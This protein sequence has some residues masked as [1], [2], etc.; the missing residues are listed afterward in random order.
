MGRISAPFGVGGQ[1]RIQPF[2]ATTGGLIAY[3]S[4]W[5]G[6]DGNWREHK[7]EH[8][9]V[10]GRAVVAKLEHCDDRD[11]AMLLRGMQVAIPREVLPHTNAGE[12]YWAD[13]IGLGV[14]NGDAYDL[15]QVTR[16]LETGANEVLVVRG[17]RE[18]LIPFIADVVRNVDL[19]SG[20]I[21][22]DWGA[23]Y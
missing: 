15:G 23:D 5:F 9:H 6:R 22:V 4:W 16:I 12:F 10:Q 1:V 11:E 21:T 14:V 2:S 3:G 13:L 8:A 20:V 18:R 17:E 19:A 7:I